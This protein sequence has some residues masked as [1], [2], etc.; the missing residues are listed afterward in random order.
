MAPDMSDNLTQPHEFVVGNRVFT[1]VNDAA[2]S[3]LAGSLAADRTWEPWQLSLYAKL[4]R[5]GA[6]CLDI[7]GNIGT[8]ALAMGHYAQGGKVFSFEP[9]KGTYDL[10]RRNIADN[11][12]SNV[13]P[14]NLGLSNEAG[15]ALI[16]VDQTLLGNAHRVARDVG[17][18]SSDQHTEAFRME[19][20]DDWMA[21]NQVPHA[22]L[23]KVDVEGY[24]LEVIAGGQKAFFGSPD[25]V[26]IFEFAVFAQR[27][28]ETQTPPN[29]FKD[30]EFFRKLKAS[31][32]HI[33]LIARDGRL[34]PVE[35]YAHLRC[36]MLNGYPVEDLLCCQKVTPEMSDM[37]APAFA[38]GWGNPTQIMVQTDLRAV[39]ALYNRWE[40]GWT[41]PSPASFGTRSIA[42]ISTAAP[43]TIRL[44]VGQIYPGPSGLSSCPTLVVVGDRDW[45]VD[46][47]AGA[48]TIS[49]ALPAGVTC[50]LVETA[51]ALQA[52]EYFGNPDDPRSVGA[53]VTLPDFEVAV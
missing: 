16:L 21:A 44:E 32:A 38:T 14:V 15:E 41:L 33:F 18:M 53:R 28:A 6:T 27:A 45:V 34:Y 23:I 7:G 19:R 49:V 1:I 29:S 43:I 13:T 11:R 20:L 25:T 52:H 17:Q 42:I 30:I 5:A 9:V 46:P 39:A 31:Y 2:D 36:L 3:L 24:E 50:V 12:M 51:H 48:S 8:S 35:S 37:V 47:I 4:I 22:D 26:A 10:L 40:D